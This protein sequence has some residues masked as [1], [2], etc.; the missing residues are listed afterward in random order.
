MTGWGVQTLEPS[1]ITFYERNSE[2]G[3]IQYYSTGWVV[4]STP[5]LNSS[6]LYESKSQ[7]EIIRHH[8]TGWVVLKVPE[9]NSP[10]SF[11]S[12]QQEIEESNKESLF[13]WLQV[14][15]GFMILFNT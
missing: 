9:L 1:C 4:E 12:S 13:S 5:E 15:G 7:A 10:T 6:S 8:G 2:F 11:T 3:E 14:L